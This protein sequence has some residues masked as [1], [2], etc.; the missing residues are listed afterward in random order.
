MNYETSIDYSKAFQHPEPTRITEEPTFA[1]LRRLE[2]ELKA[3]ASSIESD[4]GGGDH[5]YLGLVLS[6]AN[7]ALVSATAFTPSTYPGTLNIPVTATQV[8][9]VSLREDHYAQIAKYRKCGNVE[10]SLLKHL[11]GS[12]DENTLTVSLIKTLVY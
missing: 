7:Y 6:D 3:N 9:A 10:R 8:E 1:S 12:V 4:I 2:K 11:Q 5:G